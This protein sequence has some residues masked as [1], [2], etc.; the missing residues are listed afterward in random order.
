MAGIE[1]LL[2]AFEVR[3]TEQPASSRARKWRTVV[4]LEGPTNGELTV[5]DRGTKKTTFE[6]NKG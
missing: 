1:T 3:V 5:G 6:V 2:P 4:S